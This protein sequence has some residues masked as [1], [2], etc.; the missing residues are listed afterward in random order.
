[1]PSSVRG[2]GTLHGDSSLMP[3]GTYARKT[4]MDA[5]K[6][7]ARLPGLDIDI[8]RR[9]SPDGDWEQISINLRATPSFDAFERFFARAD[10]FVFWGQAA[11]WMWVPCEPAANAHERRTP[12]AR[13]AGPRATK[14]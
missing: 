8:L 7:S 2:N 10:P 6:A 12:L 4:E 1:M 3:E 9:Q 13:G 11:R 5:V 14:T